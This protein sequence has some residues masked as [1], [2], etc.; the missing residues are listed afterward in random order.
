MKIELHKIPIKEVLKDYK[1]DAEEGVTAYG[2]KLDIRPK[3]QREF[4][5]TGKQRDEVVET[6]RK[7]FPLNIMYWVK[8]ADGN[9]EVLDGQQRTIS[10]AQYVAGDFSINEKYFHSLTKDEQNQIL[11][12]ELMIYFCEGKEREKLDWF[13]IVNIAG[14]KLTD[15][16]L[17]NAVYTGPWLSDAKLHFSKTNCAAHSLAGDKGQLMKSSPIRQELLETILSWINHGK[18]EEYMSKHQHDKNADE[19]WKY[20]QKVIEWVRKT[21]PNY[22]TEMKGIEWG[23]LY[24]KFKNKKLDPEKLETEISELMQDEDVTNHKGIYLYVLTRDER[25]LN[26]RAFTDK[27]KR[28]AYERQKG[29]CP[30]CKKH[31][32]IEEMEADHI[33]LWSEGGKTIDENCQMLCRDDHR[34]KSK[35]R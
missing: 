21:F 14:E 30:K 17:R 25:Y 33:K 8:K 3:Y 15:Q 16:E 5:Y 24:N 12:Y 34:E 4:V 1:D 35:K 2:G 18:I 19:L 28:K 27:Q 13:R 11:N 10:I 7:K 23:E 31:F 29:I 26:I 32:K 9:F 20:F 6:V 22:R